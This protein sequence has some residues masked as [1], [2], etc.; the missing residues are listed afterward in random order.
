[1]Y[2]RRQYNSRLVA[3]NGG[4]TL[5]DSCRVVLLRGRVVLRHIFLFSARAIKRRRL[6]AVKSRWRAKEVLFFMLLLCCVI[7]NLFSSLPSLGRRRR[8]A[9]PCPGL[10]CLVLSTLS[11]THLVS[12]IFTS[13]SGRRRAGTEER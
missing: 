12:L 10:P 8:L 11:H 3:L 6:H 13:T 4:R 7:Q 2:T 1:M 5:L 9:L